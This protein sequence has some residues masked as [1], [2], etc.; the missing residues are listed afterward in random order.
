M[1]SERD[2]K[3]DLVLTA[4]PKEAWIAIFEKLWEI[5]SAP[6]T[7]EHVEREVTERERRVGE[8]ELLLSE[9]PLGIY[10]ANSK[11]R[12]L[13]RRCRLKTSGTAPLLA[14][15][16]SF[17]THYPYANLHGYC[18]KRS[19]VA[20]ISS[21]LECVGRRSQVILHLSPKHLGLGSGHLSKITARA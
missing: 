8:I 7:V 12:C 4:S 19:D 5:F 21:K 15:R 13:T 17:S 18:R 1:T 2:P 6:L 20:I 3:L 11:H 16:F 10:G 14:R 9:A